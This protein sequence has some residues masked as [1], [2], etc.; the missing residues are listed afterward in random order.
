M[1]LIS[2]KTCKEL[3][4]KEKVLAIDIREPYEFEQVN[5]GFINVPM[6]DLYE[7]L[8]SVEPNRMIIIMCQSGRRALAT[9]NLVE[10]ELGFENIIVMEQGIQGWQ[11]E[12]DP[13]LKL[14]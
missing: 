10:T 1:K 2:A 5:C 6:A 12:V 13:S 8:K 11:A 9:G 3:I 14:D 7:Y 4:E